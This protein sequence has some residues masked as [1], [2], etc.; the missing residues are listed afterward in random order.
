VS[1]AKSIQPRHGRL[2]FLRILH[3]TITAS[4]LPLL[5]L[6]PLLHDPLQIPQSTHSPCDLI[7]KSRPYQIRQKAE[8]PHDDYHATLINHCWWIPS[9]DLRHHARCELCG[10][11]LTRFVCRRPQCF[12]FDSDRVIERCFGRGLKKSVGFD[13]GRH[14]ACSDLLPLAHTSPPSLEFVEPS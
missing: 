6:L 10:C 8:K 3:P 4:H 1:C 13:V 7:P 12:H 14:Y 2:R 5:F 11:H 9:Q